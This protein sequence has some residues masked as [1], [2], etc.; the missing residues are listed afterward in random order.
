MT[1][2]ARTLLCSILNPFRG[3]GL[4]D[5][6]YTS[7]GHTNSIMNVHTSTWTLNTRVHVHFNYTGFNTVFI[8]TRV[9]PCSNSYTWNRDLLFVYYLMS[10]FLKISFT[11]KNYRFSHDEMASENIPTIIHDACTFMHPSR[12]TTLC[13]YILTLNK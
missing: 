7:H 10:V 9:C 5:F 4:T 13:T 8:K 3:L 11:E 12:I 1:C 6:E 2:R